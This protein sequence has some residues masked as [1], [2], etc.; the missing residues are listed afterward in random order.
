MSTYPYRRYTIDA[1]G[2]PGCDIDDLD[3]FLGRLVSSAS[4]LGMRLSYTIAE[5]ELSPEELV[6]MMDEMEA[7]ESAE[8]ILT[9]ED[10]LSVQ[11][12]LDQLF[13]ND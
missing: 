1:V 7:A 4:D 10:L 6:T 8:D 2:S 12:Q 9:D 11:H 3:D 5:D 13:D